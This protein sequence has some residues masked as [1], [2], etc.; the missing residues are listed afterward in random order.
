[1]IKRNKMIQS[2]E[3]EATINVV[4]V[5]PDNKDDIIG[6]IQIVHGMTEYIERYTEFAEYFTEK[7]YV[8]IGNDIIGHGRNNHKDSKDIH[9]NDWFNAVDDIK[10]AR[11]IA[12]KKYPNIPIFI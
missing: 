9:M 2:T 7:G 3:A 4:T 5:E 10:L 8:V 12:T 11:N 6:I 1:M